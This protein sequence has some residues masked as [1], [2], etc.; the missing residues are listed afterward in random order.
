MLGGYFARDITEAEGSS[1]A[2][3]HQQFAREKCHRSISGSSNTKL[4]LLLLNLLMSH[5][6]GSR[7]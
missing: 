2:V 6:R 5:N 1:A 3:M 4:L 7:H